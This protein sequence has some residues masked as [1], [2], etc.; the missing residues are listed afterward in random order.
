MSNKQYLKYIN[1]EWFQA[2]GWICTF[3]KF[4]LK[5]KISLEE[6]SEKAFIW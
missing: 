4:N 1:R 2:L 3:I 5:L 6:V